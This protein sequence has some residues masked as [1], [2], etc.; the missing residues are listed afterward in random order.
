MTSGLKRYREKVLA[1]EV[2]ATPK[3]AP[4][5][6][7]DSLRK[8]KAPVPPCGN[9]ERG[10]NFRE[11]AKQQ[12]VITTERGQLGPGERETA[13]SHVSELTTGDY[14]LQRRLEKAGMVPYHVITF[15]ESPFTIREYV[16]PLTKVSVMVRGQKG[17]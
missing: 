1:G 5:L 10:F 7:V 11:L 8:M 13:Y 3:Y 9:E 16:V 14:A 6:T 15:A 4:I 2:E 12:V 17:E